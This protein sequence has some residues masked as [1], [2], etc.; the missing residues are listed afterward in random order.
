MENELAL[1][2][3]INVYKGQQII[4][5]QFPEKKNIW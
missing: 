2:L 5:I 1:V 4:H 3:N